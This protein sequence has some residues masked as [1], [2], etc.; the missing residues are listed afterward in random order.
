MQFSFFERNKFPI[1]LYIVLAWMICPI[2]M[3]VGFKKAN[4]FQFKFTANLEPD[5]D[6][7]SLPI[8][9]MDP[10]ASSRSTFE[11][12]VLQKPG[13]SLETD[14]RESPKDKLEL[15][16]DPVESED[17][18]LEDVQPVVEEPLTAPKQNALEDLKAMSAQDEKLGPMTRMAMGKSDDIEAESAPKQTFS[19]TEETGP[20]SSHIEQIRMNNIRKSTGDFNRHQNS[21]EQVDY[22]AGVQSDVLKSLIK[23]L[24]DE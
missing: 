5:E 14:Q 24:R 20:P 4:R 18:K 10:F 8:P 21:D 19:E 12:P 16:S 13:P 9:P 2:L 11:D 6:G 23:R 17:S 1:I 3:W 7:L 22:L 15:N